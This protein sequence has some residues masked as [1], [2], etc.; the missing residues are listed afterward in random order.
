MVTKLLSQSEA[1]TLLWKTQAVVGRPVDSAY[2]NNVRAVI[3]ADDGTHKTILMPYYMNA[4]VGD[5]VDFQSGY[6]SPAPLCSYVPNLA[7]RKL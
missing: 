3:R 5:R 6:L 2:I 4:N 1:M 7:T